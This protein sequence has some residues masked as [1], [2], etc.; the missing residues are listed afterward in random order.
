VNR[1]KFQYYAHSLPDKPTEKWQLL[2]D[3]LRN[4]AEKAR[5]FAGLFGAEDWAYLSGLWHDWGKGSKEFQAYLRHA[6]NIIDEFNSYYQ[7][8]VDHSS[9]GAQQAFQLSKQEGKL[10]AYMI[11]GHHSGLMNWQQDAKH[12]LKYR[13]DKIVC[14]CDFQMQGENV[15]KTLPF[16][17]DQKRFGFQLQFFVRMLFSCLV[18][19][20]FL[21]TEKFMNP[22]GAIMR[23]N[24]SKIENLNKN[25]WEKFNELRNDAKKSE[26][27]QVREMVLSD[28][29]SA[30]SWN[31]GL[32]S[33]TV[34]TG[35]GKTLASMAFALKHAVQYEKRR[36]IYVIPFTS[37]IEQNAR[38]FREV[39]GEDVVLEHHCNFVADDADRITKL[40]AENWDAPV[41]VTTNV[42]FFDSFFANRTSKCRKLHSISNSVVIFDEIQAIPV[43]KLRP[44]LEVIRE[45]S[46]NYGVSSVLCSATQP[47]INQSEDFKEGLEDVRGIASDVAG[48]FQKLKRANVTCIGKQKNEDIAERIKQQHQVL[49]IV[50]TRK[51]AK[52]IFQQIGDHADHYHLSA[53]MYP[54]HRTRVLEEIRNKLRTK[55]KCRVISTQLIEAGVDVDFPVVIR[56]IAGMDSIAQAAGRCNREGLRDA[57]DVFVF[58][59]EEGVPAGYFRQTAQCAERLFDRFKEVLLNPPSIK[60]YFLNYY[61]LNQS[62]MD[63]DGVWR[64]CQ[65][66][67]R[68]DIQFEEL[69]KFRMINNAMEPIVVATEE[70]DK[71]EIEDLLKQL[72]YVKYA[73]II[74]KK[75]QKYTVQVYPHHIKELSDYLEVVEDIR[76]L[77][78][79]PL[80]DSKIGLCRDVPE[81]LNPEDTIC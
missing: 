69:A 67:G 74:L 1:K 31:P 70:Q 16:Q 50:S 66:A 7:G 35:G 41:V 23:E 65:G 81:Y 21:D 48:L 25:F 10:L 19:A 68:G 51:Q 34:P 6:N 30:A 26:V 45:L 47:A 2:E 61:W 15:P 43:E 29:V 18:D 28:C 60:E 79:K 53:L 52:D 3:H 9:F 37:I 59:P 13:L 76:I 56:S 11:A 54:A 71:K 46:L 63:Q 64:I 5:D 55:Q 73:S 8:K 12:G 62:R 49:C 24:Q 72:P 39:L 27:N 4:V 33:L 36:I 77:R 75:L 14:S 17:M 38:V 80:Y 20:D 78:W 57:G 32:F 42:Q 44:C 58:E 40:R 22:D